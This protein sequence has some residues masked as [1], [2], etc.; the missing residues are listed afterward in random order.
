MRHRLNCVA[1]FNESRF[2]PSGG[3]KWRSHSSK[4][5]PTEVLA[6]STR[7]RTCLKPHI[8]FYPDSCGRDLIR[9]SSTFNFVSTR[10]IVPVKSYFYQV[11]SS[12]WQWICPE[13]MQCTAH[14]VHKTE[15]LFS[16]ILASFRVVY[17]AIRLFDFIPVQGAACSLC[18]DRVCPV[19]C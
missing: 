10:K 16:F 8:F 2:L 12:S 15:F 14:S 18:D 19:C 3:T 6:M 5:R 9:V 13:I 1:S 11:S 17:A 4:W 7:I